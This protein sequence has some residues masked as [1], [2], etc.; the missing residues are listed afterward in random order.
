MVLADRIL[1]AARASEELE[2]FA[3][4]RIATTV[5]AGTGGVVRHVARAET[6]GMGIRLIGD[7]RMGYAS[8]SDLGDESLTLT[9]DRAR[10]NAQLSDPDEAHQL[11]LPSGNPLAAPALP[12][13]ADPLPLPDKVALVRRFARQVTEIDPRVRAIDM[14]EYRDERAEV[15]IASTRGVR[16]REVREYAELWCEA[17]AEDEH[18]MTGDY[19]YWCGRDP[20]DVDLE[21]LALTAVYRAVRLLGPTAP[22]DRSLPVVLDRDVI[23]AF[24]AAVGK[25]CTG[26]ALASGRSPF[27]RSDGADVAASCVTLVDDGTAGPSPASAAYDDEGVPRQRTELISAGRLI[28]AIHNT[29]AAIGFG[30]RAQSTGNARRSTYKVAPRTAP[31][32]L[33]LLPTDSRPSLLTDVGD[34]VY[35]QQLAGAGPGINAVTGRVDVGCVGW[36]LSDG[37]PVGRIPSTPLATSLSAMLCA[38]T[39]VGNDAEQVPFTPVSAPTVLCEAEM[40]WS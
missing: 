3:V 25:A 16:V 39:A 27:A 26:G 8:T 18:G 29:S 5:Q 38:I 11:P 15:T 24:L 20:A 31:T 21:Q 4:H 32:T 22:V 12:G 14:A 19:G 37:V 6:R 1:G 40:F 9:L 33:H 23:A 2:V 10:T 13:A 30:G 34:A 28:G 7:Q 35:I 36:R 17:L